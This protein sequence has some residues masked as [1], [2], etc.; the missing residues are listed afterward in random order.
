MPL[1]DHICGKCG[2]Q[3]ETLVKDTNDEVWCPHCDFLMR[4]QISKPADF[5]LKGS[6]W[7]KTD[8]ANKK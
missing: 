8:Y 6:G 4:K 2:F 3:K 1:V 5:N 7:Y